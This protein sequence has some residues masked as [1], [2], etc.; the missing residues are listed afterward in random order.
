MTDGNDVTKE[1]KR[2]FWVSI[3]FQQMLFP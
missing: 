3:P 1:D 2:Q